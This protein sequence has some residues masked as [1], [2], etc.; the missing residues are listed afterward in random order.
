MSKRTSFIGFLTLTILISLL[1]LACSKKQDANKPAE[2]ADSNTSSESK[3]P[4]QNE[5][6]AQ[7]DSNTPPESES[8][9]SQES[10]LAG[11]ITEQIEADSNKPELTEV[12]ADK[13]TP[14]GLIT[15]IAYSDRPCV[16]VGAELLYEGDTLRGVKVVKINEG[17][18]E[19]EKDGERWTQGAGETPNS[20]WAEPNQ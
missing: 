2:P 5:P 11:R 9:D 7:C 6:N 19:F 20:Y 15:A 14:F 4:E 16:L 12:K 8:P 1:A 10:P 3:I 17:T 13:E 18:V